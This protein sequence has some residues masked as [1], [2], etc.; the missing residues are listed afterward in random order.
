MTR[1]ENAPGDEVA[2]PRPEPIGI[3]GQRRTERG[4][5]ALRCAQAS[6]WGG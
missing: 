5:T 1:N 3:G 4:L 2:G 6:P